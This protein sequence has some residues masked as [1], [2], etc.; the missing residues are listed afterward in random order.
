MINNITRLKTELPAEI[1]N[2]LVLI[3]NERTISTSQIS[4]LLGN[5]E[6]ECGNWTKFVENLNY[7]PER[8]LAVFPK[9]VG[10]LAN[11]QKIISGGPTAIANFIYNGRMGNK[12]GAD[13]GWNYRG[14]GS[15]MIT[16]RDNY[17]RFDATVTD[18]IINN[19]GLLETKYKLK[20]AFWFFDVNKIWSSGIDISDKSIETVRRKVNGGII[21]LDDVNKKVKKYFSLLS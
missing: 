12:L 2:E 20:P 3:S 18:D 17:V 7:K 16:G 10:T 1:Y 19:P 11:A 15:M 4:H 5:A 13:D 9:R 6:H 8:L 21:G 14:R